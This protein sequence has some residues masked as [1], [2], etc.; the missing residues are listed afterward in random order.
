[1]KTINNYKSVKIVAPIVLAL[2]IIIAFLELSQAQTVCGKAALCAAAIPNPNGS[3][4]MC[5]PLPASWT[6][7]AVVPAGE[8]SAPWEMGTQACGWL[9]CWGIVCPC[10]PAQNFGPCEE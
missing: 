6:V 1:M 10:G 9:F 8:S 7:K 4:R 2:S 3:P 5:I